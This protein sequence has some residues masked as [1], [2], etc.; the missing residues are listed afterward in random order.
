MHQKKKIRLLVIDDQSG[1]YQ[2]LE[3]YADM[4]SH[5]VDLTC[6]L[7]ETEEELD[8]LLAS[9]IPSV[10]LLDVHAHA[11]CFKV[12][13]HCQ[14]QALPVIA[15][16]WRQSAEIEDSALSRGA[17]AYVR[18][19]DAPEDIEEIVQQIEVISLDLQSTH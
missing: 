4:C 12:M 9:W 8:K 6:K 14:K 1:F 13:E 16:S 19:G 17:T 11:D 18:K 7:V 10:V 15:T 2:A 3:D 5:E